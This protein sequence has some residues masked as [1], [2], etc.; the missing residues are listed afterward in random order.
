MGLLP[1][2]HIKKVY[3]DKLLHRSTERRDKHVAK[4]IG[5][6]SNKHCGGFSSDFILGV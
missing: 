1:S 3:I 6:D 5:Q 4:I 2:L